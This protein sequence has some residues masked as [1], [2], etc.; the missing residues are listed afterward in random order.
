ML[1]HV[2]IYLDVENCVQCHACEVACKSMNNIEPGLKWRMVFDFWE[3]QFP[4][5]SNRSISFA[6]LHCASPP[7]EA[8]CPTGAICKRTED[9]IVT[10]DTN[11]CIGCHSCLMACPFGIPRFGRDGRM[12]K[13]HLCLDRLNNGHEPACVATCP[14]EALHFGT[15]EDLS[16]QLAQKA[17]SSLAA[18]CLH[19]GKDK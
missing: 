12:Q 8:V 18:I 10:V 5:V 16:D 4:K 7:C 17:S 2:G 11:K 6:C 3:G 13:C 19:D 9:G 14:A 15:W 1:K